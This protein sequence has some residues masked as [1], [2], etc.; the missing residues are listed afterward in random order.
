M[1]G[2][3]GPN[4]AGKTTT[5]RILATLLAPDSGHARVLGHD[6]ATALAMPHLADSLVR[7]GHPAALPYQC[8]T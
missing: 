4:G 3:L 5:V 1:Y 8:R 2:L 7:H 6:V